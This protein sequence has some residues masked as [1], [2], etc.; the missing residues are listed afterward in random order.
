M[1]T[2]IVFYSTWR[3]VANLLFYFFSSP[4]AAGTPARLPAAEEPISAL[5]MRAAAATAL[6]AAAVKAKLMAEEEERHIRALVGTIIH[7]QCERVEIKLQQVHQFEDLM[8]KERA[9]LD[10]QRAE[11]FAERVRLSKQALGSKSSGNA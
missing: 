10:Q 4:I 3:S 8:A 11:L 7:K 6:A 9:S 5:R 2:H 1:L